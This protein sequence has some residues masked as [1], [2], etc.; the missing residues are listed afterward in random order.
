MASLSPALIAIITILAIIVIIGLIFFGW[1]LYNHMKEDK[2]YG[3]TAQQEHLV[4]YHPYD[5]NIDTQHGQNPERNINNNN[6]ER[7]GITFYEIAW[8]RRELE[9]ILEHRPSETEF[10]H[11]MLLLYPRL[12]YREFQRFNTPFVSVEAERLPRPDD[13]NTSLI[14]IS[15]LLDNTGSSENARRARQAIRNRR[16]IDRRE[17]TTDWS[18]YGR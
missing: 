17:W 16:I 5:F 2:F 12:S 15:E 4:S 13:N 9:Q 10:Y 18:R 3:G 6:T 8:Y 7:V 14:D 1:K 11:F